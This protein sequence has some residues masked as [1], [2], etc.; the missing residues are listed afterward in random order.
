M[1]ARLLFAGAALALL[2]PTAA[3][4]ADADPLVPADAQFVAVAQVRALLDAPAVQ[5]HLG[6]RVAE[7]LPRA[8]EGADLLAALGVD[9]R[10]DVDRLTV[11]GPLTLEADKVLLVVRGRFDPDKVAAAADDLAKKSPEILRPHKDG[12]RRYFEYR[13]PQTNVPPVFFA[14]P[15]KEVAVAS[16]GRETLLDALSRKEAK[17][18]V[19]LAKEMQTVLAKVDGKATVWVAGLVP[20]DL[21]KRLAPTPEY[22][23]LVDSLQHFRGAVTAEDGVKAEFLIQT[24]DAK[25]AVEIRKF[26][27]GVK[28][29][30]ILA[31]TSQDKKNGALWADLLAALKVANEGDAVTLNGQVTAEQIEKSVPAGKK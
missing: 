27:E 29:I 25:A 19:A 9:P 10:K 20:A 15:D 3:R 17:K 12:D 21:K 11:A 4:A 8:R 22:Q 18:P 28:A 5:K 1:R 14:V 24:N 30:L 16:T 26:M 31:A 13:A 6:K 7:S 2:L 23:K